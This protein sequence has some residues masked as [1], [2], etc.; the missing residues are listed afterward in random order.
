MDSPTLA[1]IA[2]TLP[3][4]RDWLVTMSWCERNRRAW[5]GNAVLWPGKEDFYAEVVQFA[6]AVAVDCSP[7]GGFALCPLLAFSWSIV[8]GGA[9]LSATHFSANFGNRHV[10]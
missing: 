7:L 6:V 5:S 8:V 3:H 9:T 10:C 2:D 4:V 1:P